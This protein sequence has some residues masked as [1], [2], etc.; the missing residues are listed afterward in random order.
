MH[1]NFSLLFLM[2]IVIL[3]CSLNT[4]DNDSTNQANMSGILKSGAWHSYNRTAAVNYANAYGNWSNKPGWIANRNTQYIDH[5]SSGGDCTNFASQVLHAGGAPFDTTGSY[6]W[7]KE[8]DS[9]IYVSGLFDYL[10]ANTY[11]GPYGTQLSSYSS[12]EP[13][14]LVQ[15][16][17]S[18]GVWFHTLIVV[19]VSYPNKYYDPSF[20][21]VNYHTT[22]TYRK[23]LSTLQYEKRYIHIN[24]WYD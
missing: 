14:D 2:L 13:G 9:F 4:A 21:W 12:L 20:I 1:S 7:Y 15:L 3:G 19:E 17:N 16:K 24:G 11:T 8:S 6:R 10:V 5:S 23:A 22:D 18:N